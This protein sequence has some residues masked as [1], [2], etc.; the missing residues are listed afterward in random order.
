MTATLLAGS[1]RK[2][3]TMNFL[4]NA[5]TPSWELITTRNS[6]TASRWHIEKPARRTIR[7]HRKPTLRP[8]IGGGGNGERRPSNVGGCRSA[9]PRMVENADRVYHRLSN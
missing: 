3:S 5:G 1:L 4:F 9:R 2:V 8:R 6:T 7:F